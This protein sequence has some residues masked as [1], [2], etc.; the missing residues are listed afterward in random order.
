MPILVRLALRNLFRHAWRTAATVLGVALGIAAVLATLSVG[1]NVRANL[2]A[3]LQAAAGPAALL[4]TPGATGRAVMQAAPL[5]DRIDG[6][7]VVVLR[8]ENADWASHVLEQA[9]LTL[10]NHDDF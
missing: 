4:V 10:V 3:D 1:A 8:V 6:H 2:Q 5:I 9:G 7:P